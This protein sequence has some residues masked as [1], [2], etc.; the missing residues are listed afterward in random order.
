MVSGKVMEVKPGGGSKS[1]PS[2]PAA[3]PEADRGGEKAGEK[4]EQI[5]ELMFGGVARD[6]DRRLKE[7][8]DGFRDEIARLHEEGL[9]RAAVLE[10]RLNT[11][12][13]RIQAQLR[14]EASARTVAMDDLDTRIGQALR[15]QRGEV[16]AIL[17]RHEDE[18]AAGEIRANDA[19][20]ALEAQVKENFQAVKSATNSFRVQINSE[21]LARADL[22]DLLGELSLRLRGAQE[23]AGDG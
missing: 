19:I 22:A 2:P 8:S 11:Q 3:S 16:N 18:V 12:I 9:K 7:M 13:E 5:R 1:G 10:A 20:Y 4:M 15:T 14:Q 6:L 21:K 23:L 17:Q